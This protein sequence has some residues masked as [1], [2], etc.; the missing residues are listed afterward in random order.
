M[1]VASLERKLEELD[2]LV[3]GHQDWSHRTRLHKIE[4]NDRGVE[5]AAQ[6]LE[7]YKHA[8]SGHWVRV[9]EWGAFVLASVAVL[10]PWEWW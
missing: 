6:A 4:D 3:E 5:L 7:A 1:V 9:R 2:D 10:R 8:R